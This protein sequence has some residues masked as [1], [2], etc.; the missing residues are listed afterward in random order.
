[1]DI[2]RLSTNSGKVAT[3]IMSIESDVEPEIDPEKELGTFLSR[4]W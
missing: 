2:D 1:M 3:E 4:Y